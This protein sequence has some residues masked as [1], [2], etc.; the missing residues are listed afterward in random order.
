MYSMNIRLNRDELEILVTIDYEH[1]HIYYTW[2][3][4]GVGYSLLVDTGNHAITGMSYKYFKSYYMNFCP[5]NV[6]DDILKIVLDTKTISKQVCGIEGTSECEHVGYIELSFRFKHAPQKGVFTIDCGVN[7]TD[8]YDF[9][10]GDQ[11]K[12]NSTSRSSNMK[13][14]L[15]DNKIYLKY[16]LV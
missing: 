6:Y 5:Q 16:D 8:M 14:L 1:H 3:D 2:T 10:I 9:L 12:P 15:T 7:D 11:N 13:Y 4:L